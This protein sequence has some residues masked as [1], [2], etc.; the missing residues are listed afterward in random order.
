MK[1]K[2]L[3]PVLLA[4]IMCLGMGDMAFAG[5]LQY[6]EGAI[7]VFESTE[8]L[9]M[10]ESK[11]S[12]GIQQQAA[13]Q[14]GSVSVP[15]QGEEGITPGE[16]S[17]TDGPSG[18]P[19]VFSAEGG[20]IFSSES[21]DMEGTEGLEYE[22]IEE[23]DSYRVVK[24]VDQEKVILPVQYQG[25]LITE[26]GQKAFDGCTNLKTIYIQSAYEPFTIQEYAFNNCT[27]LEQ[28]WTGCAINIESK[29][30]YNCPKLYH[31]WGLAQPY[32][33]SCHIAEDA[34]VM[35]AKV[36]VSCLGGLQQPEDER[37]LVY[38]PE[39]DDYITRL[40]GVDYLKVDAP[41]SLRAVN[42]DN[43]REK[44]SVETGVHSIWRRAFEGSETLKEIDLDSGGLVSIESKAFAG[45]VNLEKA[46]VPETVKEIAD[47][48]F[49]DCNKLTVYVKKGSY[50][51]Q[52]AKEHS[53]HYI[54]IP[55]AP[56]I[57]KV[58]V[59]KNMITVQFSEFT[60]DMY[61]CILGTGINEAGA[62]VRSGNNGR[63]AISQTGN[64]VVFRNVNK[65]TY[66]IGARALSLAGKEKSYSGW[67]KLRKVR[68]TADT[69]KRPEIASVSQT[70]NT[71]RVTPR[72]RDGAD[73]YIL[74]VS[75]GTTKNDSSTAAAAVPDSKKKAASITKG[76]RKAATIK[77]IKAG[78]YY[79]GIQSFNHS[80]GSRIYSQWSP[81]KKITVR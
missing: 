18:Q 30:F 4:G 19:E 66:Y 81:L 77:N 73:G 13:D 58:T 6:K 1:R 40:A 64:K 24:G 9:P 27:S 72:I 65:G 54:Y 42:Y 70:G 16:E 80:D 5:E 28:V 49:E 20:E 67:S 3:L 31:I 76:D 51:E 78:T 55:A 69:P 79:I 8:S 35:D 25:K 22:Y 75:R 62:P 41:F 52:Y 15:L 38:D 33:S 10:T 48:A 34:F 46:V 17:F 12:E 39:N 7:E 26:I 71:L 23:T 14:T 45:C 50:A 44:V 47:D 60:G 68:I 11:E 56:E 59:N 43:S 32:Q 37:Y 53:I 74:M 63:I 36:V 2:R 57:Q 29:A 61:Y 21:E